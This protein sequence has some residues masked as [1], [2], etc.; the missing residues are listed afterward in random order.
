MPKI[1]R[2]K[3]RGAAE[4]LLVGLDGGASEVKAHEVRPAEQAEGIRLELGLANASLIY[5]RVRGFRPI[6]MKTQLAER[7]QPRLTPTESR[8]AAAW[9]E[10]CLRAIQLVAEDAGKRRLRVGICMPGIKSAD[11]RGIVVMRNG[12]RIPDFLDAI[13]RGLTERGLELVAPIP[14]LISDGEA[15]GRGELLAVDGQLADTANAYY[16]GGGTGIAE[17]FQLDGRIVSIDAL[18]LPKA[19][20]LEFV[21]GISCE[22]QLSAR[23]IN[24]SYAQRTN[25]ALPLE[26]GAYPE[27]RVL[28]GDPDAE[29]VLAT[30]AVALAQLC[31]L[32][33]AALAPRRVLERIVIGQRL[34]LL[35]SHPDLAPFLKTP[36]ERTLARLV[37]E[38]AD[39]S[40]AGHYVSGASLRPDLLVAS[41]LRVAPALGAAAHALEHR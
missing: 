19:W 8:Q 21:P 27:Q 29:H 1:P 15:C 4:E 5:E 35:M 31:W 38:Q 14:A 3:L 28:E 13:E 37:E 2:K 41:T 7:E 22:D 6:Q 25:R 17:C 10:A 24:A 32:R 9:I 36:V 20:Q 34:G 40:W 30:A 33:I 23:G 12:P 16:I 39:P 26:E 11:G 18:G